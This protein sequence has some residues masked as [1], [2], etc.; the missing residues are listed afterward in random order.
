MLKWN[1]LRHQFQ[2]A[3]RRNSWTSPFS[4]L[5][6]ALL[7]TVAG[8][9]GCGSS[10]RETTSDSAATEVEQVATELVEGKRTAHRGDIEL[11]SASSVQPE[12]LSAS[13]ADPT[14]PEALLNEIARLRA[15][16]L[17]LLKQPVTGQKGMFEEIQLTPEQ[18]EAEKVRRAQRIIQLST[19]I[20]ARTHNQPAQEQA[21]NNAVHLLT[22]ARM[23]LALAGDEQQGKLLTENAESLFQ[24]DPTSFAAMESASRVL[25][26]AQAKANGSGQQD[27]QWT[28]AFARQAR[29][30]AANFPQETHRAAV[31]VLAAGRMCEELGYLSEAETCLAWVE[32]GFPETPFA[33]Q[34]SGPLRRFRLVGSPL[35]EFGG[36][37]M[38]GGHLSLQKF[39]GQTVLIAFWAADSQ[40]FR[41]DLPKIM[42]AQRRYPN[43]FA[44]IGVNMDK[45]EQ[46]AQALVRRASLDWPQIF[47]SDAG[48]RGEYNLVARHYGVTDV[49]QYW[50]LDSQGI[51]RSVN[52]SM[53]DLDQAIVRSLTR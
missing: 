19:Q 34:A 11:T 44:V 36:P 28:L 24:R 46:A 48:K 20:I 50:L 8:L 29:L 10:P 6:C 38:N 45:D 18:A 13:Q 15:A 47:Y 32:Q 33:E 52:L 25:Q 31:N 4:L 49:P 21:F 23:Q 42:A 39:Q 14:S 17:D 51:V 53:N 7:G 30:F 37:T 43:R 3:I 9:T 1:S 27:P 16:P 40:K 35:T 26:L 22:D 12:E 41:E 5:S 2:L